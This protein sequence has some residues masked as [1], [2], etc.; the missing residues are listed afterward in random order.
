MRVLFINNCLSGGGSERAMALL[1]NYFV[2]KG[3][4]ASMMLLNDYPKVYQ[5]DNRIKLIECYCPKSKNKIVQHV[6]RI[7]TIH[8]ELKKIDAEIIITFMWNINMDVILAN[9]NCNKLI[10]A[11]ER[12]DPHHETK[13]LMGFALHF[14]LPFADYTVFQ[15][16]LVKTY[17]PKRVQ[18]KSIVIPNAISNNIPY[19]DWESKNKIIIAV[20]RLAEQKNYFML[21]D[22]FELF[23][24]KYSDYKLV[25]Y[26]EGPLRNLIK[27]Q[28]K[29]KGLTDSIE[30]PGYV[31]DVND[32]M[33]QASIYVNCSNF[34][35]ISNAMLEALAMG[36]PC[37]CTDCPVG[38]AAMIIK[39]KENGILIPV[40]DAFALAES[41]ESIVEDSNFALKLSNEAK[42][43]R[44][45]YS[46]E[47]IGKK[48]INLCNEVW[49][50]SK[51]R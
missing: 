26:G 36:L 1:A 51:S 28:I 48:W 39:N 12:C 18:K 3:I 42:K 6:N 35:G 14:I 7:R 41:L 31:K 19:V 21:L 4:D 8:K 20:G 37:I 23:H 45:R 50:L 30:M 47:V 44:N 22:A 38:G 9:I 25:I 32:K 13:K 15:T 24:R 29:A 43:I 2:T 49:N 10:I 17:Y 5:I 40:G 16:P 33:K 46:M 34:E 27:Q 11:S